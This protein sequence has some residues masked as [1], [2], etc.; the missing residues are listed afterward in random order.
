MT[1]NP[2]T[3]HPLDFVEETA[4]IFYDNRIGCLPIVSAWKTS[5]NDNRIRFTLQ[6]HRTYWCTSTWFSNRNSSSK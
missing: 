2:I 4:S 1:K 6:I 3:G 5:W